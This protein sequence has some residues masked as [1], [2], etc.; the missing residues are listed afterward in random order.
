VARAEPACRVTVRPLGRRVEH[1]P[2]SWNFAFPEAT[3]RRPRPV[4]WPRYSPILD[5]GDLGSC[6]GNAMAGWLGCAPHCR[7]IDTGT[8]YTEAIA[9]DLYE[10]ATRLDAF[11]GEYPPDDTGSSGLAVAKA[12]RRRGYISAYSHAF[13]TNGLLNA[14]QHQPVIVGVPWYDEM[15]TPDLTGEVHIGG[16]LVGGHEFLIR[17]WD[18]EY[19]HADNSW[20]PGWG[21]DGSFKLSLATWNTLRAQQADVTVPHV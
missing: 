13:T 5:Q 7:S 14:L 18:G 1:D 10:L 6:T 15:F 12:A 16:Q 4:L 17:G 9:V 19:L 20:G 3:S 2:A 11:P 8:A 21:V